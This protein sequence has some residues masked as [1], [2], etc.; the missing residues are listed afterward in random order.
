MLCLFVVKSANF[1]NPNPLLGKDCGCGQTS[2]NSHGK[3]S[4][5]VFLKFIKAKENEIVHDKMCPD[6]KSHPKRG[7]KM[8]E[9]PGGTFYLGTNKPIILADG[10]GPERKTTLS[11][12]YLDVFE[13]SNE[14]FKEFVD[15]TGYKTEA[16]TFGNS[17]V[18]ES[19]LSK[20]TKAK[21]TQAVAAAPW[22]VPVE[23]ADWKHPEGPDS[24]VEGTMKFFQQLV[25]I[26]GTRIVIGK[27]PENKDNCLC[28]L[29]AGRPNCTLLRHIKLVH[30]HTLGYN[31]HSVF[32]TRHSVC[33]SFSSSNLKANLFHIYSKSCKEINR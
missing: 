4:E 18:F 17:F 16:E 12:F 2:R 10:E 7:S 15:E 31:S 26:K 29:L 11:T 33:I 1:E 27:L 9:V 30:F 21:V 24:N 20:E 23:G 8:V 14:H 32:H 19:L 28:M 25:L 13:V 3:I 5:N 22:W 6:E